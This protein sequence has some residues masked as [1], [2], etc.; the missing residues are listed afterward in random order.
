MS[1]ITPFLYNS[2]VKHIR[3]AVLNTCLGTGLIG[4]LLITKHKAVISSC[5]RNKCLFYNCLVWFSF[6]WGREDI[7]LLLRVAPNVTLSL[8]YRGAQRNVRSSD[9]KSPY[10]F[11]H[12]SVVQCQEKR[13]GLHV[14]LWWWYLVGCPCW[15]LIF[16]YKEWMWI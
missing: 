15:H 5:L 1:S 2:P 16:S 4:F 11:R 13:C 9:K 14:S 7:M 12:K 3:E 10:E 8:L 6:L